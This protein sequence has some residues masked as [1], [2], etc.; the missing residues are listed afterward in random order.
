MNDEMIILA[1]FLIVMAVF[2]LIF[3]LGVFLLNRSFEFIRNRI[4]EHKER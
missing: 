1:V 2:I 4:D 3:K